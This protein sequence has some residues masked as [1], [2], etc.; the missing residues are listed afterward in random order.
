[1]SDGLDSRIAYAAM[2]T[3]RAERRLDVS[4]RT[5]TWGREESADVEAAVDRLR[6]N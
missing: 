3:L 6:L 2:Q 4:V 1:M 5:V